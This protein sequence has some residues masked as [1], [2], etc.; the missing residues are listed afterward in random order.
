[1]LR[2][3]VLAFIATF[4]ISSAAI[5][6]FAIFQTAVETVEP[7]VTTCDINTGIATGLDAGTCASP[8]AVCDGV[9]NVSAAFV[10]F[11]TWAKATTTQANGQLIELRVTG[12]CVFAT[13]N[14]A[15]F[16]GLT[17]ARLW[18]YGA[19][20]TSNNNQP[21]LGT[22][23]VATPAGICHRGL[24]DASGCSAR[25][26]SVSAG[27][28]SVTLLNT[29][30]CSRFT[31]GRWAVVTGFDLQGNLNSFGYPPN[32]QFFDYVQIVSTA[33]CAGSGVVTISRP[34][35]YGY[36][37]TW[38]NFASGTSGEADPGG[39]ATMYQLDSSWGGE[40]DIRGVTIDSTN[41]AF[42]ISRSVTLR[43]VTMTGAACVIPTQSD[44]FTMINSTGTNCAIEVDKII[45]TLTYS[46][47][48]LKRL[49][50]QSASTNTLNWTGGSLTQDMNGTP[51][52]AIIN[53]LTTPTL[54]LGP[55][56]YGT[57]TSAI[58]TN[59]VVTNET[60]GFG[61]TE[62]GRGIGSWPF[63]TISGGVWSYPISQSVTGFVDNGS[64][65]PRV[66]VASTTG[67]S[68][69]AVADQSGLCTGT[70]CTGGLILSVV[71][72]THFDLTN[73]TFAS[74]TWTGAG[75]IYNTAE[76]ERWGVPGT[77]IFPNAYQGVGAPAFQVTGVTQSGGFVNIATTLPGGY[78]TMPMNGATSANIR[79][80]AP[81]WRCINCSGNP[82]YAGD[83][84]LAPNA[85][86]ILSYAN[87]TWTCVGGPP[88]I[89]TALSAIKLLGKVN[90]IKFN[91]TQAYTGATG[92]LRQ[93]FSGFAYPPNQTVVQG[94]NWN[95]NLRQAGLRT[96][97]PAG[98]TCDTGGGPIAGPCSGDSALT[99]N[100][101][102][103]FFTGA[104]NLARADGSP[105][106]ANWS[107]NAE[108]DMDQGVVP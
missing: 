28:T 39:P 8:A 14:A 40:V 70:G 17:K 20:F 38:P 34:L 60:S 79:V 32:P 36:L 59:C 26:S 66:T 88:C 76:Q 41:Q 54:T 24:A 50:F 45:N 65:K 102:A 35:T 105:T 1:M 57:P 64:G 63:Y 99:L 58:C 15:T 96:I 48:T 108:F 75:T 107:L 56:A 81:S 11:N 27:A 92:T 84:N 72:A 4:S 106:D 52:V 42:Y 68:T 62:T 98:V 87:R 71:D 9:T 18:G 61:I 80:Q 29:A 33:S 94:F 2:K 69:G 73:L 23:G 10:A 37:S 104:V 90:S 101:P 25:L 44:T 30:L 3:F 55:Y 97:T 67:W 91:V 6:A 74:V 12:N 77:N 93:N 53:N 47:T 5:A 95:I 100:D 16:T 46:G 83:F 31:A 22:A 7:A 89:N 86:P 21:S 13:G 82:Q 85:R 49:M 43:D 19:T 51:K 103:T 78:P